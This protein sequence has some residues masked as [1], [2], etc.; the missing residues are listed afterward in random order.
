MVGMGV[1]GSVAAV[2]PDAFDDAVDSGSFLVGG[3]LFFFGFLTRDILPSGLDLGQADG[4]S[5]VGMH[6]DDGG[7]RDGGAVA[8]RRNVVAQIQEE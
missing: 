1:V 7:Q 6:R 2:V 4:Q 3:V 5:D 8:D